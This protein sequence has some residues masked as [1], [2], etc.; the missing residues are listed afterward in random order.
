MLKQEGL[1]GPRVRFA[2]A[3]GNIAGASS[4]G[5][6]RIRTRHTIATAIRSLMTED[7]RPPA[8][9]AVV[10]PNPLCI[11][12]YRKICKSR[13]AAAGESGRPGGVNRMITAV[14]LAKASEGP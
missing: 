10:T 5:Q 11:S 3:A 12:G 4:A 1:P 2:V 14:L 7:G 8:H 6:Q 13:A 9:E